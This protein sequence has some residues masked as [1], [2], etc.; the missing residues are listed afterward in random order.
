MNVAAGG[1]PS[2]I[3]CNCDGLVGSTGPH[4]HMNRGHLFVHQLLKQTMDVCVYDVCMCEHPLSF[5]HVCCS[6]NYCRISRMYWSSSKRTYV[7]T[8]PGKLAHKVAGDT[9]SVPPLSLQAVLGRRASFQRRVR[10]MLDAVVAEATGCIDEAADQVSERDPSVRSIDGLRKSWHA[11]T[12]ERAWLRC[13]AS[14]EE[15]AQRLCCLRVR[16]AVHHR[17]VCAV[18]RVFCSL[19]ARTCAVSCLRRLPLR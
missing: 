13:M 16:P 10:R 14:T 17:T 8:V 9:L 3:Q 6:N 15:S 18:C 2:L 19:S 12:R 5:R 1:L 4:A 7:R 11:R